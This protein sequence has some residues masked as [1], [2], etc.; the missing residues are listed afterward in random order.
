MQ[1]AGILA[2]AALGAIL[3]GCAHKRTPS[4]AVSHYERNENHDRV[5]VFVH[6]I[7][8]DADD[9]WKCERTGAYW[10]K[11]IAEDPVFQS[12][13]IYV[14]AYASPYWGNTMTID[15]IVSNLSSRF[16]ADGVF[17]HREVVFVS[18]SLGGL[19]TQRFLLTHRERASQV[20]FIYFFSTPETGSQIANLAS[21][22]SA[23]PLLNEMLPGNQN[24][25]LLNLENEWIAA[26][27]NIK[28]YC[29]YEKKAMKGVLVVDRLSGTRNCTAQT[30]IPINEDHASIVKPCSRD[31]DAY[32]AFRNAVLANPI[33][34]PPAKASGA[35]VEPPSSTAKE[36]AKELAKI[37]RPA[38]SPLIDVFKKDALDLIVDIEDT[39]R[40][41][42]LIETHRSAIPHLGRQKADLYI[43]SVQD[44]IEALWASKFSM[45]VKALR[46]ELA[47]RDIRDRELDLNIQILES[48]SMN[49]RRNFL[50][51][52]I[53]QDVA[54]KLRQ[55]LD[56]IPPE[57]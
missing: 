20:P 33:A 5:I 37:E 4:R 12:S 9:T 52:T 24:D 27:F 44:E 26:S 41:D 46:R 3:S 48:P 2:L 10:P 8:G 45:R 15:E 19:I 38:K 18:H 17:S 6:G 32:V 47:K 1:I 57:P 29:A 31:A 16:D 39:D 56:R 21:V 51:L 34:P 23:D 22:F 13:D 36:I 50:E 55:M 30:P 28:R 14:A 7:F 25:Y 43:R 35:P 42:P 54:K 49:T 11:L 53:L 40:S